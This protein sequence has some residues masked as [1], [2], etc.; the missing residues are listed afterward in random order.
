MPSTQ[1]PST[2]VPS[3]QADLSRSQEAA[4]LWR[5]IA[6][7]LL[8]A[9]LIILL[10]GPLANPI[11]SENLTGPLARAVAPVHRGLFQ[12]HGYRFFGP[13]PGPGHF[14]ECRFT[15]N[16]GTVQVTHFPDRQTHW[17]RLLYH[18]WFM[19][20]ETIFTE[21]DGTPDA[22]SFA[23]AQAALRRELTALRSSGKLKQ[24]KQLSSRI[25]QLDTEYERVRKRIDRLLGSLAS[26]FLEDKPDAES[27]ELVLFERSIPLP[28]DVVNGAKLD[29]PQYLSPPMSIGKF[30]RDE[31]SASSTSGK[32]SG[33]FEE[34]E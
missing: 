17:P 6:S 20:A 31:Q 23:E 33:S 3:T 34:I 21:L 8:F 16:D 25:D 1:V 32:D 12:G 26:V 11:A 27:V 13:E 4:P 28:S 30:S 2:Q 10:I 7:M 15:M 29:D 24:A 22:Q 9:Y 14:V 19:L 5:A 18:R